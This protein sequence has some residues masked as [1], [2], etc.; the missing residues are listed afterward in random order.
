MKIPQAILY[1]FLFTFIIAAPPL[2]LQYTGNTSL[3]T[4]GFWVL[5][6]FISG[7]TFLV[8][9]L[10][11]FVGE[12]NKEYFAQGFLGGTTFK[13]LACLV[14]IFVFSRKNAPDK[15]VFLVN[16]TYIYLLNMGF[17]VYVLLRKLRHENLR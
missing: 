8:L 14:F 7:I 15:T 10:M 1:F 9:M 17:E 2:V 4:P 6:F 3:L 16:F 5:F 11:L 13:I 12:K